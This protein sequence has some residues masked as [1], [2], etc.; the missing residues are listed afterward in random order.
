MNNSFSGFSDL[1]HAVLLIIKVFFFWSTVPYPTLL[2][3]TLPYP[4]PPL[5]YPF[6]DL[7]TL[8]NPTLPLPQPLPLPL[9]LPYLAPA[10]TLPYPTLPYP[11]LPY[12]NLFFCCSSDFFDALLS[13]WLPITNDCGVPWALSAYFQN[14]LTSLPT[15]KMYK[16]HCL[17]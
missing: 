9:P 11:T 14:V 17:Q 6:S 1:F 2:N 10:L 3:P 8:L 4:C 13:T 7:P 5:P 12:S 15:F 16:L